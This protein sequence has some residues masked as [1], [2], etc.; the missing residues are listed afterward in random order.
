M[1]GVIAPPLNAS[2]RLPAVVPPEK[3]NAR[4]MSAATCALRFRG[5]PVAVRSITPRGVQAVT[6]MVSSGPDAG[7]V[8]RL[9]QPN[10]KVPRSRASPGR[11][12]RALARSFASAGSTVE[13]GGVCRCGLGKAEELAHSHGVASLYTAADARVRCAQELSQLSQPFA[14][15]SLTTRLSGPGLPS[16]R[17]RIGRARQYEAPSAR[18]W[19]RVPAA[20]RER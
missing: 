10:H 15:G 4:M 19:R 17:A 5:P 12:P 1:V 9:R 2:V 8:N 7:C 11:Q 14:H 18:L 20:Q 16:A 6:V 13:L 3:G